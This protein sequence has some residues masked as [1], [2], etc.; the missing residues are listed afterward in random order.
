[1]RK[2]SSAVATL[3]RM[4]IPCLSP[5]RI[6]VTSQARLRLTRFMQYAAKFPLALDPEP[7]YTCRTLHKTLIVIQQFI[8]RLWPTKKQWLSWSLPSKLTA[9]G[10]LITI[11]SLGL[12]LLDK[13]GQQSSSITPLVSA[14]ANLDKMRIR[15]SND[16][17]KSLFGTPITE[18]RLDSGSREVLYAFKDYFLQIVY[19]ED[20]LVA[21]F[22]VTLRTKSF[23]YR[24]PYAPDK[25]VLGDVTYADFGTPKTN[26]FDVGSKTAAYFE[27]HYYGNPGYYMDFY[28]AFTDAGIDF[29]ST[30]VNDLGDSEIC[31]VRGAE[32]EKLRKGLRPNTIGISSI[33]E[34]DEFSIGP[35]RLTTRELD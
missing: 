9:L 26:F 29:T 27:K 10:T 34:V 35:S 28:P 2:V 24:I 15:L 30:I 31:V 8:M 17:V 23:R 3:Q 7:F 18:D 21:F 25:Y 22:A 14:S 16:Y 12:Y 19:G 1:M 5:Y 11:I 6:P 20:N 13:A 33:V 32:L 4:A